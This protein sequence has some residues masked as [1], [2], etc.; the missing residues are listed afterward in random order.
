MTRFGGWDNLPPVA[1]SLNR[2]DRH[3]SNIPSDLHYTEEHEYVK[4]GDEPGTVVI[5][6][7]DYAQGELGDVV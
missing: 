1:K 3:M 5:G 4:L 7:T 6:I 2:M